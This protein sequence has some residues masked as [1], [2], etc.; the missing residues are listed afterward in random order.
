MELEKYG[1]FCVKATIWT[2]IA[3]AGLTV[4]TVGSTICLS[5]RAIATLALR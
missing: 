2:A 5:G 3:L 1:S 4:A